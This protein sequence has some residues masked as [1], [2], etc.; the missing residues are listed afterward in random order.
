MIFTDQTQFVCAYKT[1]YIH[2][3]VRHDIT[4]QHNYSWKNIEQVLFENGGM[5]NECQKSETLQNV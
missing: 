2:C 3:L 1:V 5:K 4:C